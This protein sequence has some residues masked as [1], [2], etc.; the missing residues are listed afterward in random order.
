MPEIGYKWDAELYQKSSSWQFDLGMMAINHLD[1]KNSEE[2][3][4]IGCGNALVTI[5]LAKR[6]PNGKITAI[7]I[8]E[9]MI[10]Q[11]N[12]NC[13][14]QA[15]ENV[16]IINMD[17]VTIDFNMQFDAV[18]SNSAIHWI[19]NLELM[20][21]KIYNSLRLNGRIMIQTALKQKSFFLKSIRMISNLSKYKKYFKNKIDFPWRFLSIGET[22]KILKNCGFREISINPYEY[23]YLFNDIKEF[24]NF[25]KAAPLIPYLSNL[26]LELN[27]GFID[28]FTELYSKKNDLD[29][30]FIKLNRVFIHA[31]K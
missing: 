27:S 14:D 31:K 2:I 26:P 25:C 8:S 17:A 9:N 18:F 5:E 22:K 28:D 20:Y 19:K 15:I 4:E 16:S 12:K 21:K 13:I 3:L 30:P 29:Q 23:K 11:A 10:T 6:I 7:E 1:P 24:I